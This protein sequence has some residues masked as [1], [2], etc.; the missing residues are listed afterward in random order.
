MDSTAWRIVGASVQGTSHQRA[1]LPCQDAYS[2]Q[3]VEDETLL[4][5]V[6]DGAGS[7]PCAEE[8]AQHAVEQAMAAMRSVLKVPTP[9]TEEAWITGLTGV[10]EQ[11]RQALQELAH[12]QD[13]PLS[14]FATTLLCTMVTEQWLIAGQIGDGVI[15]AHTGD[16]ALFT[17]V[18]PQRGEYANETRFLTSPAA[19][20]Y[21]D[22]HAYPLGTQA[23]AVMTDGLCHLALDRNGDTPHAPF[24]HPLFQF[25]TQVES[26]SVGQEQLAAFLASRRVCERTDDDKTL[27]LACRKLNIAER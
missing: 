4:I 16:D 26:R 9:D 13:R 5:A 2:I 11:A 8:G 25:C 12:R 21:L 10:F 3:V 15:V 7:A 18:E 19:L 27:V 20:D 22:G 14:Q 6:A 23:V 24:F 1:D 17:V